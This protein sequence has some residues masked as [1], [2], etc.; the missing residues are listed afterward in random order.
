MIRS[1]FNNDLRNTD[2][3]LLALRIA[4]GAFMLTH[5]W[6]KMMKVINGDFG[7]ADPIGVGSTL[8]LLLTVFAE[9]I[10]AVLIL[11]GFKGR[12]ASIFGMITMLV[13]AFIVHGPDPWKKK[14]MA[15]LYF[16]I[17]LA[18]FLMGTGKLGIEGSQKKT[19][20][21]V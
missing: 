7:F 21:S 13:A 10:C 19:N 16:I 6:G 20:V 8:S 9:V 18:I 2:F 15:L 3:G 5:G 11:V 12:F 4:G 14:E 17:Y 1:I